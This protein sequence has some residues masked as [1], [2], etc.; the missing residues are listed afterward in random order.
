MNV[1]T[2]PVRV[3][4][5]RADDESADRNLQFLV[6]GDVGRHLHGGGIILI[7]HFE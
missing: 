2:C 1:V 7:S 3:V 5:K 4:S 6:V